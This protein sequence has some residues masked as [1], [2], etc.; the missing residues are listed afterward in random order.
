MRVPAQSCHVESVAPYQCGIV[1]RE[2]RKHFSIEVARDTS[3]D[4]HAVPCV[5]TG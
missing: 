5:I 4:D 1:C 3:F 2:R